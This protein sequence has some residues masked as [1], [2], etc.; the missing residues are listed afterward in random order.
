MAAHTV[1]AEE[2]DRPAAGGTIESIRILKPLGVVT[3]SLTGE[4]KCKMAL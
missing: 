2:E 1:K 4:A 3:L